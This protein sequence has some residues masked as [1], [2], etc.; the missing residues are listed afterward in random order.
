M[1]DV[2]LLASDFADKGSDFDVACAVARQLGGR[3]T[4]LFVVEPPNTSAVGLYDAQL[5]AM[6]VDQSEQGYNRACAHADRFRASVRASGCHDAEWQV[7]EGPLTNAIATVAPWHDVLVLKRDDTDED[8]RIGAVSGLIMAGHLPCLVVPGIYDGK[9]NPKQITVACNDSPES[10]RALRAALPLLKAA[11][12][13]LILQGTLPA[14]FPALRHG[15]DYSAA[16]YLGRYGIRFVQ[17]YV[18]GNARHGEILERADAFGTDL[19]VMG[20]FGR[21]RAAEWLLGGAT[22]DVLDRSTVPVLFSR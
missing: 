18:D 20:A 22:R 5:L 2:L 7:V 16:R 19:L 21:S 13:V 11:D 8:A 6:L 9:F 14:G 3:L 15:P 17:E 1:R 10:V 4:G 12:R